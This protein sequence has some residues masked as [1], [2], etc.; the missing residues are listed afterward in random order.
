M[1]S[2]AAACEVAGTST[3]VIAMRVMHAYFAGEETL[4]IYVHTSLLSV[5]DTAQ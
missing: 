4:I 5:L 1:L 3:T 2:I